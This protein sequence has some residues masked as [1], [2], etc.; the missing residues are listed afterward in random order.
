MRNAQTM[1]IFVRMCLWESA[2][3]V[4]V[5]CWHI[6]HYASPVV[7][8]FMN[9]FLSVSTFCMP[10]IKTRWDSHYL[11]TPNWGNTLKI[12]CEAHI[13]VAYLGHIS[14]I[15][16][17]YWRRHWN[18]CCCQIRCVEEVNMR[19][20]N[21]EGIYRVPGYLML[22]VCCIYPHCMLVDRLQSVFFC[23]RYC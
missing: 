10:V 1:M 15:L 12:L 14:S 13:F 22:L 2:V 21:V 23:L 7:C 8:H 18:E 6:T 9:C 16:Q 4:F 19:G 20:W 5:N 3:C 17:Q 11:L